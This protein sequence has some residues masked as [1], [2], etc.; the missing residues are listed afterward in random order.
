MIYE[1]L[2]LDQ[3]RG[4]K[5]VVARIIIGA[6]KFTDRPRGMNEI[7]FLKIYICM[8]EINIRPNEGIKEM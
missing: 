6:E 3:L 2:M 8:V 5:G 4:L 7:Q 1:A